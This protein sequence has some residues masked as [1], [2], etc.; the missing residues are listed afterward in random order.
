MAVRPIRLFPDPVLAVPCKPIRHFDS[1][2]AE[3]IK[4]LSDTMYH[5]PGVGLAA[6]QI[7]RSEQVSFI[8]VGRGKKKPAVYHG[9]IIL[10]N[11]VLVEGNGVQVPREGC[12]SVPDL[13]ANVSRYE[14]VVVKFQNERGEEITIQSSG[15]EALALQHEIDHLNGKL[16]LDRVANIKTDLFRR[17]TS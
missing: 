4:D 11:P 9:P 7:G 13:L 1:A 10:V 14:D 15:F 2:L 6:P 16:F 17:K 8:D 3:L 5:S 12:L